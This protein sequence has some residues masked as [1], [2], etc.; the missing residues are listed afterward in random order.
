M[1]DRALHLQPP[2]VATPLLPAA[3]ALILARYFFY[4]VFWSHIIDKYTQ[5]FQLFSQNPLTNASECDIITLLKKKRY[6]EIVSFF[7]TSFFEN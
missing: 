4:F 5:I 7:E 3:N 1:P 2:L 6:Q